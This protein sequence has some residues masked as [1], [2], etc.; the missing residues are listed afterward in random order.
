MGETVTAQ[1][2]DIVGWLIETLG[3]KITVI[4]FRCTRRSGSIANLSNV[5]V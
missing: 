1:W 4:F 3:T 2:P 5:P